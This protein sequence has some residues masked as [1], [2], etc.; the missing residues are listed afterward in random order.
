MA[1]L[2]G[3]SYAQMLNE[4]LKSCERRIGTVRTSES[5]E[6]TADQKAL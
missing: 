4:I 3:I 2:E 6:I 1:K 5:E